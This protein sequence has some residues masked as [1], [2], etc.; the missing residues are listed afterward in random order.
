MRSRPALAPMLLA[1]LLA[2]PAARAAAPCPVPAEMLDAAPLP[3]TARA[4]ARGRLDVLV[5]GSAS[6]NGPGGSG[7]EASYPRQLE[8]VLRARLP[9]VR[10]ELSVR[11]GRGLTAEAQAALVAAALREAPR[12]LVIWQAG[13]VE[14]VRGLD[15]AEMT[16]VL[17]DGA[18]LVRR[19]GADLVIMDQ[20]FSRFMRGNADVEP[21]REALRRVAAA[22]GAGFFRRWDI[23]QAWAEADV[24]DAERAPREQQVAEVDRLNECLASALATLLLRE[25][26]R[27]NP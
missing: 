3:A 17:G 25:I 13:T 10:I 27:R 18:A 9:G 1:A 22:T 2:G 23:M 5:V 6:V 24:V 16:S 21:Y 19:A 14:A 11:G 7:P 26:P 4:V 12:Q 8:G 20:Q 15:I